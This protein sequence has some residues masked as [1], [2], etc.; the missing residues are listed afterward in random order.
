MPSSKGVTVENGESNNFC[1]MPKTMT[2]RGGTV[3]L[4]VRLCS[5]ES[6]GIDIV[7]LS[8]QYVCVT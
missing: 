3:P 5:T 8:A 1:I 6:V 7:L 2:G 4:P